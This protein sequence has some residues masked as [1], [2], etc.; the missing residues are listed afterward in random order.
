MRPA[1]GSTQT[2]SVG[3]WSSYGRAKWKAQDAE[4]EA[5]GWPVVN[6][7]RDHHLSGMKN[8][9]L[10]DEAAADL[11]RELT[12]ITWNDRDPR[13]PRIRVLEEILG[14]LRRRAW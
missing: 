7:A 3:S 9:E 4:Q 13:S 2:C 1:L 5:V 8:R 14:M 11:A 12:D 10:S 6:A